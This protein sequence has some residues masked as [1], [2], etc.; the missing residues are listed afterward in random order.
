MKAKNQLVVISGIFT[1]LAIAATAASGNVVQ[2]VK[3]QCQAGT[4]YGRC[5]KAGAQQQPPGTFGGQVSDCA[6]G[7][8]GNQCGT[9]SA[10]NGISGDRAAGCR[11]NDAGAGGSAQTH[12]QGNHP[13]C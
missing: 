2:P 4:P 8:A 13:G 1:L 6:Q 9:T 7:T 10:N 12:G 11:Y 5:V 3:A